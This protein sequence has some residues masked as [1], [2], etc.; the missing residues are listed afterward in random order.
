MFAMIT[1]GMDLELGGRTALVCGASAGIGLACAEALAEEGANVVVLARR[2][3]E[4]E[5]EAARI[6]ALAVPG[7]VRRPVDLERAVAAT[8]DTYGGL[9]VLIPNS[10]GP[11]PGRAEDATPEAVQDAVELVLLP[12]VRLVRLA[13]PHLVAG[14][15]GRIVLISSIAV[16]EPTPNLALSNAVKPGVVGYLKT[17]AAELAPRGVTVNAVG[18][19]R[20]ATERMTELYGPE[21]P[22]V[23]A[24]ADPDGALRRAARACRPRGVP[25]LAPCLLDHREPDPG[26]R[27]ALAVAALAWRL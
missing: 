7:D 8:V 11:P 15:Q 10:G 6:G 21:P 20:I 27:R 19:G 12:V 4:L 25:L 5:R 24:R 13:L 1:V 2:R 17:L 16:R 18:P 14:G 26:R 3:E 22:G 23:G 9:D